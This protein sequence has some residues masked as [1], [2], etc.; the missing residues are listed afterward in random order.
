MIVIKFDSSIKS[1]ALVEPAVSSQSAAVDHVAL[2]VLVHADTVEHTPS[3][4][5]NLSHA[6]ARILASTI[7]DEDAQWDAHKPELLAN[8]VPHKLF[9]LLVHEPLVVDVEEKGGRAGL[10]LHEISHLKHLSLFRGQVLHFLESVHPLVEQARRHS[11]VPLL[12]DPQNFIHDALCSESVL[13]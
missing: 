11:G 13:G 12:V 1:L 7:P 6:L 3:R 4:S 5:G 2:A 10:N 9:K 8:G